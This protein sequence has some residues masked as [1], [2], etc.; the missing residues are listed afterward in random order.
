MKV[1]WF[2]FSKKNCLLC[3]P[4]HRQPGARSDQQPAG[5]AVAPLSVHGEEAAEA[6][7]LAG[8]AAGPP[9]SSPPRALELVSVRVLAGDDG[10]PPMRCLRWR[11]REGHRRAMRAFFGAL[12]TEEG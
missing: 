5:D 12:C 3:L 6:R 7:L 2:F 1:F 8:A 10:A 11:D 9:R 4:D